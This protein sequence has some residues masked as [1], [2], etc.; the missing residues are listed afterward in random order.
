MIVPVIV[1]AVGALGYWVYSKPKISMYRGAR[2][3][4]E[5][6]GNIFSSDRNKWRATYF[7]PNDPNPYEGA[8]N[9]LSAL[10]AEKKAVAAIDWKL[11]KAG[12][13]STIRPGI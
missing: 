7:M 4:V 12:Q 2:I 1:V 3:E 5:R 8:S 13:A 11:S 9:D 10:I 6:Q